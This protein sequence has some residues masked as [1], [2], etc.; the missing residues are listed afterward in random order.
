MGSSDYF[1]NYTNASTDGINY[2]LERVPCEPDVGDLKSFVQR[3][4]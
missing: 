4:S 3:W 1:S 2:Y